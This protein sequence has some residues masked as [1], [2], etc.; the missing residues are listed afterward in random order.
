MRYRLTL[1]FEAQEEFMQSTLNDAVGGFLGYLNATKLSYDC[2]SLPEE[3]PEETF[4]GV[5]EEVSGE[6]TEER[7]TVN[8]LPFPIEM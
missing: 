3:I 1:D 6:I 5:P 8:T 7:K 2:S 4:E